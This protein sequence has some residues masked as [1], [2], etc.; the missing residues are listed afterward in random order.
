MFARGMPSPSPQSLDYD[1]D[2]DALLATLADADRDETARIEAAWMLALLE[3]HTVHAVY[4]DEADVARHRLDLA[5][6]IGGVLREPLLWLGSEVVEVLRLLDDKRELAFGVDMHGL[7]AV[8]PTAR[9]DFVW[10]GPL[11]R[12]RRMCPALGDVVNL[13][14]LPRLAQRL[15]GDARDVAPWVRMNIKQVVRGVDVE[16]VHIEHSVMGPHTDWRNPPQL[17]PRVPFD[18][19]RVQLVVPVGDAFHVSRAWRAPAVARV[20]ALASERVGVL[21][22]STA[23][24]VVVEGAAHDFEGWS[25]EPRVGAFV[26]RGEPYLDAA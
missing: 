6:A 11:S 4:E 12:R 13:D 21:D 24:A 19:E 9:D 23:R 18:R 7:V 25:I 1:Q 22:F 26:M 3:I 20:V 10:H 15:A 2:R 16:V 14:E 17:A 8:S 5:R